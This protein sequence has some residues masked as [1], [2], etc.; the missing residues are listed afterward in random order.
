MSFGIGHQPPQR[1]RGHQRVIIEEEHKPAVGLGGGLVARAGEADIFRIANEHHFGKIPGDHVGR[2]VVRGIIHDDRFQ[3]HALRAVVERL[4]A[5][6]QQFAAVPIGDADAH[7][8]RAVVRKTLHPGGPEADRT[9]TPRRCG[10]EQII[11][12]GRS[13]LFQLEIQNVFLSGDDLGPQPGQVR[14]EEFVWQSP[15]VR[16]GDGDAV[17]AGGSPGDAFRGQGVPTVG[18][19]SAD[20]TH[21]AF[22]EIVVGSE[23]HEPARQRAAAKRHQTANDS[24]RRGDVLAAAHEQDDGQ[25]SSSVSQGQDRPSAGGRATPAKCN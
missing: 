20:R 13:S 24:R 9:G 22:A 5:R 18:A 11:G 8:D 21:A 23:Y 4:Q 7:I 16:P 3:A 15:A 12:H 25:S 6:A 1:T 2:P 17:L 19:N 14:V 10:K